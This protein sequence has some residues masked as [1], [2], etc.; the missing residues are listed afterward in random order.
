VKFSRFCGW[1]PQNLDYLPRHPEPR[2]LNARSS[3]RRLR[4]GDRS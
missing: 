1:E 4:H 3:R 2:P